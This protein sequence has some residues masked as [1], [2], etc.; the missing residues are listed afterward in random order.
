MSLETK[1]NLSK[2]D[3]EFVNK[4]TTVCSVRVFTQQVS[5]R[6]D[7]RD[8]EL[9]TSKE[10]LVFPQNWSLEYVGSISTKHEDRPII[11]M[12]FKIL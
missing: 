9:G 5:L 2:Q 3:W 6:F 8:T 1:I 7:Q 10:K 11:Y 12:T 4:L